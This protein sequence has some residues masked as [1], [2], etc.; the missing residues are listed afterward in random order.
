MSFAGESVPSIPPAPEAQS[1]RE[2]ETVQNVG[3]TVYKNGHYCT[4]F[5]RVDMGNHRA[6]SE[7]L[8]CGELKAATRVGVLKAILGAVT[9]ALR[10]AGVETE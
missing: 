5:T 1:W 2:V 9:E 3:V 6:I 7:K 10:D 4:S 8:T